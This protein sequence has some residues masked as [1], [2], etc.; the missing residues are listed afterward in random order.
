M[1]GRPAGNSEA[2]RDVV[3]V[4][5]YNTLVLGAILGPATDVRL[6]YI[7]TVEERELAVTPNPYLVPG[8]GGKER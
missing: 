6:A 2:E 8:I 1:R 4:E 5:D 7:P 3:H